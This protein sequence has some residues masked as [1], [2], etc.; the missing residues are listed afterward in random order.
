MTIELETGKADP[1]SKSGL[2]R[3]WL[4]RNGPATAADIALHFRWQNVIVESLLC[5]MARRL[6][7]VKDTSA[8]PARWSIHA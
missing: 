5:N 7:L 1:H 8:T 2:I 3:R 4:K 6:M